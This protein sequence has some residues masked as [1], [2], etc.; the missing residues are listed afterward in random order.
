MPAPKLDP[1]RPSANQVE[2]HEIAILNEKAPADFPF[3]HHS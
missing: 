1:T 2:K 3:K